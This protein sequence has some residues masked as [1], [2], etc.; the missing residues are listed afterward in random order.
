MSLTHVQCPSP[1]KRPNPSTCGAAF[2]TDPQINKRTARTHTRTHT[3][4]HT[5]THSR[6]CTHTCVCVCVCVCVC[7]CILT[8]ICYVCVEGCH[9]PVSK[10][11]TARTCNNN[12]AKANY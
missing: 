3:H 5:H 6:A 2:N 10:G 8:Y 9:V 7:M 1:A 12:L 11:L 4:T